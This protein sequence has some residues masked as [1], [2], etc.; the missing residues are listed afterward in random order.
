MWAWAMQ[1]YEKQ[2]HWIAAVLLKYI[3]TRL[4]FSLYKVQ[5]ALVTITS[6]KLVN[7]TESFKFINYL[8]S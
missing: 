1:I 2:A 6:V 8:Y 3:E 7:I 5:V 4:Y